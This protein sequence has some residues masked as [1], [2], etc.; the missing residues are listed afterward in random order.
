MNAMQET[1]FAI[2][3]DIM[4]VAQEIYDTGGGLG[5]V[6]QTEPLPQLPRLPEII[7]LYGTPEDVLKEHKKKGVTR[8]RMEERRKSKALRAYNV[9]RTAERF[10]VYERIYFP[11]NMDYRGRCYPIPTAL[12]PQGTIY[13]KHCCCSPTLLRLRRTRTQNG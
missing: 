7:T 12:T 2:N 10:S 4:D 11:W 6:P 3:K 13:R 5:G 9:L 8:A 1:P